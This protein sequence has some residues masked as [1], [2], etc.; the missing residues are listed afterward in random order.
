VAGEDYSKIINTF[1]LSSKQIKEMENKIK[2]M[3]KSK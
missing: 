3:K 1:S 2:I